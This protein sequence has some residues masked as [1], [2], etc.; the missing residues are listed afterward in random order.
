M[1]ASTRKLHKT[2]DQITNMSIP[3]SPLLVISEDIP[4]QSPAPAQPALKGPEVTQ[5]LLV[6]TSDGPVIE[7]FLHDYKS[8]GYLAY[9][10][11]T[12]IAKGILTPALLQSRIKHELYDRGN[13]G[14]AGGGAKALNSTRRS[15]LRRQNERKLSYQSAK[16]IEADMHDLA[17]LRIA[18]YHP[19]DLERVEIM[20]GELF[21]Q[22]KDPQDWPD[23]AFGPHRY[24]LLDRGASARANVSGR[25]SR[26]P[27][28]F[29]RHFRVRL[30]SKHVMGHEDENAIKGLVLE[31]QLMSLLM[32]TWSVMHHELIYKPRDELPELDE[33]DERLVDISNGIIISGEQLLRQIEIN[34]D[35]KKALGNLPFQNEVDFD[36]TWAKS[37]NSSGACRHENIATSQEVSLTRL[38]DSPMVTGSTGLSIVHCATTGSIA[39]LMLIGFFSSQRMSSQRMVTRASVFLWG[40][41]DPPGWRISKSKSSAWAARRE[42]TLAETTNGW[43]RLLPSSSCATT[44]G[45]SPPP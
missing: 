16:E 42:M 23:S 4:K 35:K 15:I 44:C 30:A 25:G 39:Q 31:I 27:G 5:V 10:K 8:K 24:P 9:G 29:A 20:I 38:H 32:H 33:D 19:N 21:E 37:D 11:V 43:A 40:L 3:S 34:L 1:F 41:Q 45:S 12:E 14:I 36:Y 26:F 6:E 18:L 28:Y 2:R 17:G 7:A 13:E 22:A